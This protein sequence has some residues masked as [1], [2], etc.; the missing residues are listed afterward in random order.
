MLATAIGIYITGLVLRLIWI[1]STERKDTTW[2]DDLWQGLFAFLW[3]FYALLF[4]PAALIRL[5]RAKTS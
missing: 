5:I 2:E 1:G 4:A 3:P